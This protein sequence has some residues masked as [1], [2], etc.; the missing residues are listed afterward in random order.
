M[1]KDLYEKYLTVIANCYINKNFEELYP[2]LA[3]DIVWESNWVLEPR[4][5]Y[6]TVV[7][8]YKNKQE[9]LANSTW[10]TYHC[11]VETL[12]PFK[13]PN[14]STRDANGNRVM[15]FHDTGLLLDYCLQVSDTGEKSDMIIQIKINDDNKISR[16]DMCI[17]TLFNY[18]KYK[19]INMENSYDA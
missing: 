4:K 5:G 3:E 9:Q 18:K 19:S 15:L 12:D 16:I 7:S 14:K 6:D 10:R 17:P 1:N 11:L 2:L 8:Y 13:N